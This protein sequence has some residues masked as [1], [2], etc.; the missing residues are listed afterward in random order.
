[1]MLISNSE[2][3]EIINDNSVAYSSDG[4]PIALCA[5]D[6]NVKILKRNFDG[7][8]KHTQQHHMIY[9]FRTQ[10]TYL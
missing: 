9:M 5:N 6:K 10:Q 1:M 7:I 2:I 4:Q 8:I 3:I